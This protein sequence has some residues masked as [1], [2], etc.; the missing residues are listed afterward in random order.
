MWSYRACKYHIELVHALGIHHFVWIFVDQAVIQLMAKI[1][2]ETFCWGIC[3]SR[4]LQGNKC[5]HARRYLSPSCIVVII[6]SDP[7]CPQ[8]QVPGAAIAGR[9]LCCVKFPGTCSKCYINCTVSN[10][11]G[12]MHTRVGTLLPEHNG[13]DNGRGRLTRTSVKRGSRICRMGCILHMAY[14]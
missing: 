12:F 6:H 9:N 4:W 1:L 8:Q 7:C 14:N 13:R 5:Q 3:C 2:H 11:H 10:Y